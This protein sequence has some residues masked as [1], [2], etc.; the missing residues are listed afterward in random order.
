MKQD[1]GEQKVGFYG[2]AT[3]GF[4][5]IDSTWFHKNWAR[6]SHYNATTCPNCTNMLKLETNTFLFSPFIDLDPRDFW[7]WFSMLGQLRPQHPPVIPD[8]GWSYRVCDYRNVHSV[9]S[10]CC[11]HRGNDGLL[12]LLVS[13]CVKASYMKNGSWPEVQQYCNGLSIFPSKLLL[14]TPLH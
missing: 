9:M 13:T 14:P 11:S 5:Q 10:E 12:R 3:L 6:G 7:E 4:V 2:A 8:P 1:C